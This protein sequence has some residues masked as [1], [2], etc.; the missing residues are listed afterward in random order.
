MARPRHAA[1]GRIQGAEEK[2]HFRSGMYPVSA[3]DS[4]GLALA[5]W[6]TQGGL[7]RVIGWQG[8]KLEGGRTTN[9]VPTWTNELLSLDRWGSRCVHPLV[10]RSDVESHLQDHRTGGLVA[11][12]HGRRGPE[13]GGE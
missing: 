5:H 4:R 13:G 12:G 1:A 6:G 2:R 3:G 8:P 10:W 7:R 9:S 11:P